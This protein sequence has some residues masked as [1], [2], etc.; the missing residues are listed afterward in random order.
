MGYIGENFIR[1]SAPAE[2]RAQCRYLRCRVREAG[3][4][5]IGLYQGHTEDG[6]S[7][8]D[9]R[10]R[11]MH[12][13]DWPAAG[14][15]YQQGMDT[16]MATF[17]T[18]CPTWE[19]W[20]ASHVKSCRLVVT[21]GEA[22][23]G[24]AALSAVSG[25]CVYAGVA[26]LS[27]YV[28]GACRGQ[29]IGKALLRQLIICSE[30]KGF[31][32]LQSGIMQ[33]NAASISLHESCGFRRVGCREKIGRDRFGVWRNTVLMERRSQNDPADGTPRA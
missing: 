1:E 7:V 2:A 24:F 33:E 12:L 4:I 11:E 31:W 18:K 3:Q 6:E 5:Q 23:L 19:Q 16:N 25:R 9:F 14:R 8:G 21:R 32:T 15:I 28:D 10:I 29:G 22:V 13:T 30:E 27:I 17:E 20:D 26:E